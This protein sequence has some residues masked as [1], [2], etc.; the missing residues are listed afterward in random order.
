[1][2]E[3]IRVLQAEIKSALKTIEE[4]YAHLEEA[5]MQATNSS[6]DIVTAYYLHVLYG[7]FENL[8]IQIAE[9]FGNHITDTAKWHTQLLK[10]MTLDIMPV[11]PAVISEE[12]YHCLNELR[13]F[14]HLFRNAYLLQ[15]DPDRL[16]LVLKQ[17]VKLQTLYPTD[18]ETFLNFLQN[19]IASDIPSQGEQV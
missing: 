17:A 9:T 19:L 8:F 15:F 2:V 13:S 14:R 11:R 16:N 10:R 6:Q 1:M 3:Q 7:V 5:G 18:I 12:T 4:I